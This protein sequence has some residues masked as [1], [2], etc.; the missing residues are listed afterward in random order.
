MARQKYGKK[1]RL[2]ITI[3]PDLCTKIQKLAK[4]RRGGVSGVVEDCIRNNIDNLS[5]APGPSVSEKATTREEVQ[6]IVKE[7][8][9]PE[10]VLEAMKIVD[11]KS[12]IGEEILKSR[13]KQKGKV[14]A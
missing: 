4:G 10:L 6:Q 13:S 2:T 3:A 11:Q 12:E 14:S 8:L 5:K 1:A 9:S 7:L